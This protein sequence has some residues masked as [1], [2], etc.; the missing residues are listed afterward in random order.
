MVWLV[1]RSRDITVSVKM[2]EF[3]QAK[4]YSRVHD[5]VIR[6]YHPWS[7]MMEMHNT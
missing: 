6:V 4:F 3:S 7:K 1:R 5:A 2:A